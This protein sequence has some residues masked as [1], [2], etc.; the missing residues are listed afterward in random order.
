MEQDA[1]DR[2]DATG[3]CREEERCAICFGQFTRDNPRAS[4]ADAR[5]NGVV[6]GCTHDALLHLSCLQV[7]AQQRRPFHCPL[8]RA[9]FGFSHR[10]ICG[11]EFEERQARIPLPGYGGGW[12]VCDHCC[13]TIPMNQCL[14]HCPR[15]KC[16]AHQ[17]GY[18]V[19]YDCASGGEEVFV[20]KSS[21]PPPP[22]VHSFAG[23]V[24]RRATTGATNSVM[25]ARRPR[26][27]ALEPVERQSLPLQRRV[28]A[29]RG[30]SRTGGRGGYG[31]GRGRHSVVIGGR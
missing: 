25:G 9:K 12:I 2:D 24:V 7:E 3:G 21:P 13:K 20:A 27:F 10:C 1:S 26:N 6:F 17:F 22:R 18:D 11:S 15:G 8:C 28:W 23:R 30:S 19:C 16:A 4:Q 14:Y 29:S 31:R 5:G